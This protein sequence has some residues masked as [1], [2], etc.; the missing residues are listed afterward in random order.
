MRCP[1]VER[2][3]PACD[4]REYHHLHSG[5]ARC[6]RVRRRVPF[7]RRDVLCLCLCRCG[8]LLVGRESRRSALLQRDSFDPCDAL[9]QRPRASIEGVSLLVWLSF[10]ARATTV[11]NPIDATLCALAARRSPSRGDC[12]HQLDRSDQCNGRS[13]V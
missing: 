12:S 2:A 4:H 5:A 8:R 7:A 10:E 6:C 3:V 11:Y 13:P 9:L 1:Q